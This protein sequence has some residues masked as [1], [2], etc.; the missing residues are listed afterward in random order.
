MSHF[1][2]FSVPY[3]G[4]TDKLLSRA[5]SRALWNQGGPN[6]LTPWIRVISCVT[7]DTESEYYAGGKE[8]GL[9]LQTLYNEDGFGIRYGGTQQQTSGIVGF[10][11][12]DRPVKIGG[13]RKLRPSPIITN[14]SIDEADIGRKKTNFDIICYSLEHFEEVSKY[15]LNPG[16]TV[17]VEWGWNTQTARKKWCGYESSPRGVVTPKQIAKYN[18]YTYIKEKREGSNFEYDATLGFITDGGVEFGDQE[19]YKISVTLTSLGEVAE[20]MQSHK[21]AKEEG[22]A[23]VPAASTNS[24]KG[25]VGYD[26]FDS[27]G[28]MAYKY[29]YNELPSV[30]QFNF[31]P[32][33]KDPLNQPLKKVLSCDGIE[34]DNRYDD[35][36]NYINLNK[37]KI[38]EINGTGRFF[39]VDANENEANYTLKSDNPLV[40]D[41]HRFIRFELAC[42]ILNDYSLFVDN[43]VG[44]GKS[45]L[46]IKIED[47]IIGAFPNMYSTNA[48]RLFIPN[49]KSPDFGLK[50]TLF[51]RELQDEVKTIE[52]STD[53][54]VKDE[55]IINNHPKVVD[56]ISYTG[57]R[58]KSYGDAP[59]PHAFPSHEPLTEST[60]KELNKIFKNDGS[61]TPITA[62]SGFWGYLKNLYVNYDFFLEQ[63][64]SPNL[65]TKDILYNL[66]N[67]M[68]SACGN[69]WKFQI[70]E[71]PDPADENGPTIL[72]VVDLYFTGELNLKKP[73][74]FQLRGTTSPFTSVSFKTDVPKA[75]QNNIIQK[76]LSNQNVSTSD[77][78]AYNSENLQLVFGRGLKDDVL[79][80]ISPLKAR[81]DLDSNK[82]DMGDDGEQS[83]SEK[84]IR[85]KNYE[86]LTG[87][88][89]I[90]LKNEF[91]S[92]QNRVA[93]ANRNYIGIDEVMIASWKDED[94]LKQIRLN[95]VKG[96]LS[97]KEKGKTNIPYGLAEV[98]FTVHGVSGFKRGDYLV[99]DGLPKNFETD[100]IYQVHE[101]KHSIDSSGWFTE[102]VTKM[103]PYKFD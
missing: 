31:K 27:P 44:T 50:K 84:D 19:T 35:A 65:F 60:Y 49:T 30:K 53:G 9:I 1:P 8:D 55:Y 5:G 36:T 4:V 73:K 18:N 15:F 2:F 21:S 98:N 70:I 92:A 82:I 66:L 71:G 95:N 81:T 47:T 76:R 67:G 63:I 10:T 14:L 102:I 40:S 7:K 25:E 75:Q 39:Q 77:D 88:G 99:Y 3:K 93:T 59:T 51:S 48:T 101:I 68:S 37:L 52:F 87:K 42:E 64:Q 26:F 17:L 45:G 6:G 33:I 61:I 29:M 28:V 79:K 43:Q 62:K 100:C 89:V 80:I 13:G 57:T 94:L 20:Y 46:Q 12:N 58:N 103:R 97:Q 32:V 34:S 56:D 90:V 11:L 72:R 85:K 23:I 78:G 74:P 22:K 54:L 83:L 91:H 41:S 24:N 69:Q 16:F 38:R 86:Y 96:K